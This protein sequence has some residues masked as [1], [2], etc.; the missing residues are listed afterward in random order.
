MN[1]KLIKLINGIGAMSEL[2]VI[3]Y[4][5]F[6]KQ[7]MTDENAMLHTKNFMEVILKFGNG[8]N[9]DQTQSS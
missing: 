3:I 6:K 4:S 9:E 5:G 1:D 7:G 8:L 2:W